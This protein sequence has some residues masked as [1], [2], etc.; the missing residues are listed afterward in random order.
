MKCGKACCYSMRITGPCYTR[1]MPY[2]NEKEMCSVCVI[3]S[4]RV[5][6]SECVS[7][8][9]DVRGHGHEPHV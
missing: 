2:A 5:C 9:D 4:D 7:V 1:Y 6:E 3:M 8:A